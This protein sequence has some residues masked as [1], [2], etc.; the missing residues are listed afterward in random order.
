[1]KRWR[2]CLPEEG[3]LQSRQSRR[4]RSSCIAKGEIGRNRWR[5]QVRV[6]TEGLYGDGREGTVSFTLNE[7]YGLMFPFSET[8]CMKMNMGV[9]KGGRT[10]PAQERN[11]TLRGGQWK[12]WA[13]EPPKRW[14]GSL[15]S[16]VERPSY[17]FVRALSP[18]LTGSCFCFRLGVWVG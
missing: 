4:Q 13:R 5:T 12:L 16:S 7:V 6:G 8:V 18:S 11:L 1:M 10:Y 14:R 15:S 3:S 9:R 2:T 17:F